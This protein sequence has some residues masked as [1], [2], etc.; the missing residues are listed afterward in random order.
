MSA[1]I[2]FKKLVVGKQYDR[3][4]LARIWG[5]RGHQAL[6]RGVV[7]PIKSNIIILFV[8]KHKQL[9]LPQYSDY[10]IDDFLYWDTEN[11]GGSNARIINAKTNG[12]KVYLFYRAKHHQSFIFKGFIEFVEI[13]DDERLPHQ[14]LFKVLGEQ[15]L[16]KDLIFEPVFSENTNKTQSRSMVLSRIG[17]GKFRTGVLKLWN[18]CAVNKINIPELLKASH[19]KPWK[20]S[21]DVEKLDPYNGLL[22]SPIFDTLFDQGFISFCDDGKI[23]LSKQILGLC[24]TLSISGTEKLVK[25]YSSNRVYLKFHREYIFL[26]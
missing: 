14:F 23:L 11:K 26:K 5:Y 9:S 24:K 12:D 15:K 10:I 19:I 1:L 8:T 17:Q 3:P 18:G 7:T 21:D 4:E 16:T 22:L 20:D 25:V 6:S 2:E 13:L